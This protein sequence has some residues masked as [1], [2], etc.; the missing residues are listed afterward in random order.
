MKELLERYADTRS[1]YVLARL[2]FPEDTECFI[3]RGSM[4]TR[5][6][7]TKT[8]KRL[9]LMRTL[10]GWEPVARFLWNLSVPA[11]QELEPKERIARVCETERCVNPEHYRVMSKTC[12]QG[13]SKAD[14]TRVMPHE[15]ETID[16][17][18]RSVVVVECYVC[19]LAGVK[20]QQQKRSAR[21]KVEK[22]LTASK[23]RHPAFRVREMRAE[24][25]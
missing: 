4:A 3:W 15:Y 6:K 1:T 20:K 12:P 25:D 10:K 21:R 11:G 9:A 22:E 13:H 7:N 19:H 8:P 16:G 14:S 5:H 23:S 24:R 18:I 17:E 2:D